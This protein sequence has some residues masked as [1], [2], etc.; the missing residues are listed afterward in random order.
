MT[1]MK[2]ILDEGLRAEIYNDRAA[3]YNATF[4]YKMSSGGNEETISKLANYLNSYAIEDVLFEDFKFDAF[5][6]EYISNF[7]SQFLSFNNQLFIYG[8]PASNNESDN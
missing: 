7:V 5:D 6:K 1:Y 4:N 2:K 8:A 3:I